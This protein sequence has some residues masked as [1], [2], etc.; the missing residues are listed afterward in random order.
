MAKEV[1]PYVRTQLDVRASK[2][3]RAGRHIPR[4]IYST[5]FNPPIINELLLKICG[6]LTILGVSVQ[7]PLFCADC[8]LPSLLQPRSGDVWDGGIGAMLY[9]TL[10]CIT[11]R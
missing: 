5:P 6:K 10:Q 9:T 7:M 11:K 8:L 2:C 4:R 1:L 3:N